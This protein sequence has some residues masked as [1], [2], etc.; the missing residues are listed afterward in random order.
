M[1]PDFEFVLIWIS[2]PETWDAFFHFIVRTPL[3]TFFTEVILVV[4]TFG[5]A[6][7]FGVGVGFRVGFGVGFGVVLG[8]SA[9][10]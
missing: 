3:F 5:F 6:T 2:Y 8:S 10:F 1:N 4:F 7:G 9:V